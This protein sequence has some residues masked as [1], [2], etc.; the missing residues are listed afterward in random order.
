MM[1][2]TQRET[3]CLHWIAA[4]KSAREIA[5]ILNISAHTVRS[6]VKAIHQKLDCVTS[7]QAVG[8]AIKLGLTIDGTEHE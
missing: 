6:Y 3:E 4:G 8:M 5:K 2:L 7:A 1:A